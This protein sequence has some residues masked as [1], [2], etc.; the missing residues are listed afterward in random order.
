MSIF[1]YNHKSNKEMVSSIFEFFKEYLSENEK[2]LY[3]SADCLNDKK[4]E[5]KENKP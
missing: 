1:G 5:E 3:K 2:N 4:E